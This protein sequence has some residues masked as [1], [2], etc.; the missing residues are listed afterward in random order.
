MIRLLAVTALGAVITFGVMGA[1]TQFAA[2]QALPDTPTPTE[3]ETPP[4]ATETATVGA[5]AVAP[6]ATVAATA[7]PPT[8]TG[9]DSGGDSTP[10]LAFGAAGI[11]A[12][13]LAAVGFRA[14]R[15]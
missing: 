11:G 14:L 9:T 12:L 1:T 8:G 5:T 4:A 13:A 3:T 6:T 15:R 2:G 10:W 7:L